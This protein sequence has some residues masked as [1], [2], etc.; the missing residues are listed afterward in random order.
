MKIICIFSADC[1]KN[2]DTIFSIT[3]VINLPLF[4][5]LLVEEVFEGKGVMRCG[6]TSI[7]SPRYL[8]DLPVRKSRNIFVLASAQC[9]HTE[10][11]KV[12]STQKGYR[13]RKIRF[14]V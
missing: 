10:I 2:K 8:G 14:L 13:S 4:P 7:F 9:V 3:A 6:Y 1:V 11:H 12:N 5:N